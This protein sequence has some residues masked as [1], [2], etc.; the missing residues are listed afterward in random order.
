MVVV[1]WLI[2]TSLLVCAIIVWHRCISKILRV[3]DMYPPSDTILWTWC[4]SSTFKCTFY[5]LFIC[6][7]TPHIRINW[8]GEPSGYAEN[9]DNW[10]F[11]WKYVTLAVWSGKKKFYKMAVLGYVL[12]T[13]KTL[14]HNPFLFFIFI[15]NNECAVI[16]YKCISQHFLCIVHIP[17]C[18]DT[19]MSPSDSLQTMPC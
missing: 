10:I 17:T 3:K 14:I 1:S 13:N 11:L 9:P 18:F 4:S 12:H 5:L 19:F 8:D 15:I 7:R 6:S 16:S 2:F